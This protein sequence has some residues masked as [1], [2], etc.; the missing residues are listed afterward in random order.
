MAVYRVQAVEF[1]NDDING[2]GERIIVEKFF[3]DI[4]NARM[5]IQSLRD[6]AACLQYKEDVEYPEFPE[7]WEATPQDAPNVIIGCDMVAAGGPNILEWYCYSIHKFGCTEFELLI[8]LEEIK[9][10]D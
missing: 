7:M 5:R 6:E 3:S 4:E 10:I 2:I 8:Y 1:Y 9:I